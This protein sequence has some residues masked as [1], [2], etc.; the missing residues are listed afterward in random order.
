MWISV[1]NLDEFFYLLTAFVDI[2]TLS[3]EKNVNNL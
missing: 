1:D 3:Q 2:Q